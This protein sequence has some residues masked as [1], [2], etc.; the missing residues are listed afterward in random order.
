LLTGSKNHAVGFM[1]EFGPTWSKTLTTAWPA[2]VSET[3]PIRSLTKLPGSSIFA[4]FAATA[5]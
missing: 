1:T 5:S 4:H 2:G 3:F